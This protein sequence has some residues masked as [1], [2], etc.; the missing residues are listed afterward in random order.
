MSDP[1]TARARRAQAVREGRADDA[2]DR[3][4]RQANPRGSG[5]ERGSRRAQERQARE[6]ADEID[7]EREGVGTVDR[8]Q[9]MDVFLRSPGVDQFGRN[10]RQEFAGEA[11]FVEADDVDPR[12]D[13]QAITADP[14]IPTERRQRVARRARR[15]L[16]DDDPYAQPDDFETEVGAF[17]VESAA[18]T[19]DGARRRAGRQFAAETP[20]DTVGPDDV[21]ETDDGFTLAEEPQRQIAAMQFVDETPLETV[22]P[23]QDIG[24]DDDGFRL[25]SDAQRRVAARQFEQELDL[26]GRGELD[27]ATDIRDMNGQFA[28]GERPARE[29]AAADID[30]QIDEFDIGP[31]DI[32]LS[33][34]DDGG[35]EAEFER[36]LRL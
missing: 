16:A 24:R 12:V 31:D 28:L 25:R 13:G 11:D 21:R 20:L 5:R 17:G 33:P 27:P 6:I 2:V 30:E 14:Q 22:D 19:D 15:G 10:V 8:L 34:T 7:I 32:E 1:T 26:F 35:F 4:I 29:V 36:E 23:E 3:S 9:G 18:F